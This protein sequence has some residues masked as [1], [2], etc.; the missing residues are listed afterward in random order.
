MIELR[1]MDTRHFVSIECRHLANGCALK[2]GCIGVMLFRTLSCLVTIICFIN[3]TGIV[4][5]HA[6]KVCDA[7]VASCATTDMRQNGRPTLNGIMT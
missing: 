1:H 2:C 6:F 4:P 7:V 5:V 3:T